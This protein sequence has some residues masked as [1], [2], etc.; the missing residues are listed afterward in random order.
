MRANP[1]ALACI[2]LWQ[3]A[4]RTSDRPLFPLASP[5]HARSLLQNQR[6][7]AG[8]LDFFVGDFPI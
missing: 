3:Y 7:T 8:V 2:H 1:A 4:D 5:S 6:M